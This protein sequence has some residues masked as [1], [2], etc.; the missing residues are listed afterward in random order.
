MRVGRLL[1]GMHLDIA[2]H[3]FPHQLTTKESEKEE[4]NRNDTITYPGGSSVETSADPCCSHPGGR[5]TAEECGSPADETGFELE[6]R[7][8][9]HLRQHVDATARRRPANNAPPQPV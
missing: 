8:R 9:N 5:D 2:T 6:G 7:Q 3:V 4:W 1:E